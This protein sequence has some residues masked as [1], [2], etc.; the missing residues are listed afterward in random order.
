MAGRPPVVEPL[1]QRRL[2]CSWHQGGPPAPLAGNPTAADG[3][4]AR[5]GLDAAGSTAGTGTAATAT[6]LTWSTVGRLPLAREEGAS[7]S[8]DG[9]LYVFG[10]FYNKHFDAT[11]QVDRFDPKTSKWTR[12]ADMPFPLTHAATIVT[13]YR[14]WLFGGYIGTD[15]GPSTAAVL[16]YNT[17]TNKWTRGPDMPTPRGAGAAALAGETVYIF[18]GRNKSRTAD[19]KDAYAYNLNTAEYT[20]IA[21]M[22]VPRNHLSGASVDGQVYAIG[23]QKNEAA[24]SQNLDVVHRYNPKRNRWYEAPAMPGVQSHTVSSTLVFNK[25]IITVG[26]ESEHNVATRNTWVFDPYANAWSSLTALPVVRRAP[27][28][29]MIG[30]KIYLAGGSVVGAQKDELYTSTSLTGLL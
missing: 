27:Q 19:V 20:P 9:K 14:V 24:L 7:A 30:S 23:G 4:A 22:P 12:L 25:K 3:E 5:A 16:V 10:G 11:T 1:E 6:R 2:M 28:A 15:P 8:L 13:S 26:G 17:R 21:R 18:G 29:A